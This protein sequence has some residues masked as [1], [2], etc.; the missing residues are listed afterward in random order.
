MPYFF[1]GLSKSFY[2]WLINTVIIIPRE[3]LMIC[4]YY[5]NYI[6]HVYF[7]SIVSII[8]FLTLANINTT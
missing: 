3:N 1:N 4:S 2:T 7:V 8:S 6:R 5:A